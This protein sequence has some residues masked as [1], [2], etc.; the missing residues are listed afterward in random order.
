MTN[1]RT[2]MKTRPITTVR[3]SGHALRSRPGNRSIAYPFAAIAEIAICVGQKQK[4]RRYLWQRFVSRAF[5]LATDF[6][7]A[8]HVIRKRRADVQFMISPVLRCSAPPNAGVY[9]GEDSAERAA[10]FRVARV[11]QRKQDHEI[12]RLMHRRHGKPA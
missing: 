3:S 12:R 1:V 11:V 7:P 10:L 9:F 4:F 8:R 6:R 5:T 2:E